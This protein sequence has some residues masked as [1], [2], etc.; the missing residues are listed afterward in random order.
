MDDA[1]FRIRVPLCKKCKNHILHKFNP[2]SPSDPVLTCKVFGIVSDDLLD[3]KI[4][5]CKRY[6]PDPVLVERNKVFD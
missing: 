6:D 4:K 3:C 1:K 2:K 5:E